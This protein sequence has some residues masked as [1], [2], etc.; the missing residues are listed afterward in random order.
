MFALPFG[1]LHE[2]ICDFSFCLRN[3]MNDKNQEPYINE[4]PVNVLIKRLKLRSMDLDVQVFFG[5]CQFLGLD[6]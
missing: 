4:N 3:Q 1:M 5:I 2:N 6:F